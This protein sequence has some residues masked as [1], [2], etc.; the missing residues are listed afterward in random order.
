MATISLLFA[1]PKVYTSLLF[2]DPLFLPGLNLN[3]PNR[4]GQPVGTWY[5]RQVSALS[6]TT[7][8]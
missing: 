5:G 3:T 6:A 1:S 2:R 4:P 8:P 7:T